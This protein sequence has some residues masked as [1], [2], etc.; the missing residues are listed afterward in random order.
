MA[1]R[2]WW[3]QVDIDMPTDDKLLGKPVA[4]RYLWMC[5]LCLAKKSWFEHGDPT[6]LNHT[7]ETLAG[8]YNI[9]PAKDVQAA[10]DYFEV[11]KPNP[12]IKVRRDGAII[13]LNFLK[14]QG[15][16]DP[17]VQ[18][19]KWRN[20]K[21]KQRGHSTG[22]SQETSGDVS[23]GHSTG[24]SNGVRALE[25]EQDQDTRNDQQRRSRTSQTGGQPPLDEI[26]TGFP[27]DLALQLCTGVS[28][29]VEQWRGFLSEAGKHSPRHREAALRE[30]LRRGCP[31]NGHGLAYLLGM[32]AKGAGNPQPLAEPVDTRP[33]WEREGYATYEAREAAAEQRTREAEEEARRGRS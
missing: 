24:R 4:W 31:K 6:I 12:I 8:K 9:H 7:A 3:V 2:G 1:G 26:A 14:R 25:E 21:R 11:C 13:L 16:H 10:L 17:D 32:I 19:E 30:F 33:A 28:A 22:Q 20:E 5:L 23:T 15:G 18:R 27:K 29:S